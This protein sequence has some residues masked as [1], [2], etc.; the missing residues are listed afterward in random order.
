MIGLT[1]MRATRAWR[2]TARVAEQLTTCALHV[3]TA[4]RARND[5]LAPGA[6]LGVC[7]EICK[8]LGVSFLDKTCA[9]VGGQSGHVQLVVRLI[10]QTVDVI[11][12]QHEDT[13]HEGTLDAR[14]IVANGG[15]DPLAETR[16]AEHVRASMLL[17]VP[18][19]CFSCDRY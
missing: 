4:I 10:D 6:A 7:L 19:T 13:P 12:V 11:R 16:L 1:A 14:A 2:G 3:I 8:E 18:T 9:E 17:E 15:M 5:N